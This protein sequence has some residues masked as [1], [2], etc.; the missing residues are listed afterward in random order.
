MHAQMVLSLWAN[1]DYPSMVA[2]SSH[3]RVAVSID[4]RTC[5]LG[6]VALD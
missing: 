5:T 4:M 2:R 1:Y 6:L 3:L